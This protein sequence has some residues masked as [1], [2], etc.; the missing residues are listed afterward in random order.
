MSETIWDQCL[1]RNG[2]L[3]CTQ[4]VKDRPKSFTF[5]EGRPLPLDVVGV[6]PRHFGSKEEAVRFA[7]ENYIPGRRTRGWVPKLR[8]FPDQE[9]D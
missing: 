9:L 4:I 3:L 8:P 2:I 7:E 5:S 6:E 1:E